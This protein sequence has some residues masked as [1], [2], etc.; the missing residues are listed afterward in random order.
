[1]WYHVINRHRGALSIQGSYKTKD[2]ADRRSESITGGE[3]FVFASYSSDPTV[4]LA[5]FRD[6]EVEGV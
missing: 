5:E 3:T 4:V 6:A 1:M 2:A